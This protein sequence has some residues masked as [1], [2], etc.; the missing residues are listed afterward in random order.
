MTT[1]S[2]GGVMPKDTFLNLS[3]DKRLRIFEAAL[4][5]FSEYDFEHASLNKIVSSAG[6]SKGSMYQYF[7]DKKDLYVYVF[8]QI[9]A[10]KTALFEALEI[11]EDLI[12]EL[13]I[14]YKISIELAFRMPKY[15]KM[16]AMLEKHKSSDVYHLIHG[17]TETIAKQY[18]AQRI[19]QEIVLG[20]IKSNIEPEV[21]AALILALNVYIVD[22]LINQIPDTTQ[23]KTLERIDQLLFILEQGIRGGKV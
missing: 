23:K 16:M 11:P 18:F 10:Q 1:W 9:G 2:Q 3:E 4:N 7:T 15:M 6:I 19:N 21:L 8:Q 13:R 5:E 12:E 22:E 14:R 20:K 17:E